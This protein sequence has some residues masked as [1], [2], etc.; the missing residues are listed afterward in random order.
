MM[1]LYDIIRELKKDLPDII[2]SAHFYTNLYATISA[3]IVGVKGIGAIRGDLL[4]ELKKPTLF[5]WLNLMVPGFLIAN[6]RKAIESV[7][8]YGLRTKS[9]YLLENVVDTGLFQPIGN[10]K[11]CLR[12]PNS[13]VCIICVGRLTKE[14]RVDI[15]LRALAGIYQRTP[16]VRAKIIGGGPL[17]KSLEDLSRELHLGPDTVEFMGEVEDVASFYQQADI[18]VLT[19]DFEGMPNVVLE[20]MAAGLPVVA[21]NAGAVPDI[22]YNC[23]T[24]YILPV[25]DTDGFIHYILRLVRSSG[26]RQK[27]GNTARALVEKCF[28]L[29]ILQQ[30]LSSLYT[31]ILT[32]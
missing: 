31:S 8:R 9:I 6:S 24:G 20:A 5:A 23:H 25:G 19:S 27:M 32:S 17:R 1:R 26:L 3:R 29:K 2:H 13:R 28:S 4:A 7:A 12:S 15:F 30:K 10:K 16:S 18:L 14:K 21:T 22:M 11:Q